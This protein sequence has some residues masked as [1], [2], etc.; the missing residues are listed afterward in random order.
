MLSWFFQA[1]AILGDGNVYNMTITCDFYC[2]R[3]KAAFLQTQLKRLLKKN[4]FVV[5]D[6]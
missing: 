3:H 1:S 4:Q 5:V 6:I 2:Q